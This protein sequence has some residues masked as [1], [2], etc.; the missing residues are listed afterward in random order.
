LRPAL[1]VLQQITDPKQFASSAQHVW[2]QAVEA[3]AKLRALLGEQ[4]K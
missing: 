4:G 2:A 1:N 3:E